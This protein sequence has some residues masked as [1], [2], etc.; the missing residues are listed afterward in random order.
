M[1]EVAIMKFWLS[2]LRGE[3]G[4][5]EQPKAG[6]EGTEVELAIAPESPSIRGRRIHTADGGIALVL[7]R[8]EFVAMFDHLEKESLPLSFNPLAPI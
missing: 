6:V 4:F 8:K 1:E 2:L 5:V 3:W 7:G